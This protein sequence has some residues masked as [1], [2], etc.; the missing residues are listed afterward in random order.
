MSSNTVR[1]HATQK[2]QRFH[3]K[4]RVKI[5]S[6]QRPQFG[7]EVRTE[8]AGR[9]PLPS[10]PLPPKIYVHIHITSYVAA[11]NMLL[12]DYR[13]TSGPSSKTIQIILQPS[14]L[15]KPLI[16]HS[17]I[18]PYYGCHRFPHPSHSGIPTTQYRNGIY[19]SEQEIFL[20]HTCSLLV[21]EIREHY[22]VKQI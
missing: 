8:A 11:G 19:H 16:H 5:S 21:K 10:H 20:S 17:K 18:S 15:P 3:D 13:F 2:T 7:A 9:P 14:H 4:Y 1:K 6:N 12:Y 22:K